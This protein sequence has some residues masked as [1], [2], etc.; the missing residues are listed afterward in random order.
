MSSE[1]PVQHFDFTSRLRSFLP[2]VNLGAASTDEMTV[3][4]VEAAAGAQVS[5]HS[6]YQSQ[7][8]VVISGSVRVTTPT[9]AYE[10]GRGQAIH[11]PGGTPHAAEIIAS[12]VYVDVFSPVRLDLDSGTTRIEKGRNRT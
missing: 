8:T 1:S 12:A 10:L 7:F 11:I 2:G 6:H 9:G 5:M 4:W 3:A